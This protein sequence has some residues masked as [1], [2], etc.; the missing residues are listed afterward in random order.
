MYTSGDPAPAHQLPLRWMGR[1]T[2]YIDFLA[3][4]INQ[5]L[6]L[7]FWKPFSWE[8]YIID[9]W[10]LFYT[11]LVPYM[12]N[13]HVLKFTM[14]PDGKNGWFPAGWYLTWQTHSLHVKQIRVT[15]FW[16]SV[17]LSGESRLWLKVKNDNESGNLNLSDFVSYLNCIWFLLYLTNLRILRDDY[18]SER[19]FSDSI[20]ISP[21]KYVILFGQSIVFMDTFTYWKDFSF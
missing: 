7:C 10:F 17:Y 4:S 6:M 12:G 13:V 19:W 9:W 8:D 21:K 11:P 5:T 14:S 20:C 16:V 3:C 1:G 18:I 2:D 15:W